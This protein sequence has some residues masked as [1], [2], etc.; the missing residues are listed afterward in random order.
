MCRSESALPYVG[1]LRTA[2]RARAL[3]LTLLLAACAHDAPRTST[4]PPPETPAVDPERLLTDAELATEPDP[5][6]PNEDE[7][8]SLWIV[9]HHQPVRSV[10]SGNF[11]DLQFLKGVIGE[12]RIVQLGESGH[13]VREFDQ[14]KVRLIRFLHEQMG[15]DVIAFESGLYECYQADAEVPSATPEA[16]MRH[17]IFGVW[18]TQEVLALFDYIRQTR[19]TS[20]PLTLAGFDI[21]VSAGSEAI[22]RPGFF[23]D[24]VAKVDPAYARRVQ[25][26]DSTYLDALRAGIPQFN[27]YTRSRGAALDAAYDSLARFFDAHEAGL[28]RAYPAQPEVARVARRSALNAV[29][30]AHELAGTSDTEQTIVR[31]RGMADNVDFLVNELYPGKKVIVWAHNAHVRHAGEESTYFTNPSMGSWIVAR[32]RPEL[33]TVGVYMYR[34][35]A[36]TNGRQ[37]YSVSIPA[38]ERGSLESVL[39]RARK[40]Y[41]FVDMLGQQRSPG[42]SW[43][44]QPIPSHEWGT[45]LQ[46]M[47]PRDQYDGILFVDTTSPPT[48]LH[49]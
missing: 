17:C 27:E 33:Y 21:Q 24:L 35:T 19:S 28:R 16:V 45:E 30:F 18:H 44:F 8:W 10:T 49:P 34:G 1:V 43:M 5:L 48:Y 11:A 4:E 22:G 13:G 47:V 41:L 7:A 14:A 32:H 31:D 46:V 38:H 6:A 37:V 23:R 42:N 15:F 29:E 12:R 40:K 20:R 2:R 36:A 26:M 9:D 3:A 39:Y 25:V